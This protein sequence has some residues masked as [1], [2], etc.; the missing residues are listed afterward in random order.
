[1]ES[2]WRGPS[3]GQSSPP[4]LRDPLERYD[5]RAARQI[6]QVITPPL[7]H[8]LPLRQVLRPVVRAPD[9]VPFA[10]GQL[11][12]DDVC[13]VVVM[14][15]PAF[16]LQQLTAYWSASR[17]NGDVLVQREIDAS[18]FIHDDVDGDGLISRGDTLL[19]PEAEE[20]LS[21]DAPV[22]GGYHSLYLTAPDGSSANTWGMLRGP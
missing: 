5:L 22:P 21:T 2:P 1:M 18:W 8:R 16:S 15:A 19:L 9:L 3:D 10:V 17:D 13:T 7:H 20:V 4:R 11:T 6:G 12:L 14:N